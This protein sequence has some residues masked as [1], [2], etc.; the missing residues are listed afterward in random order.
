MVAAQAQS[1]TA[2]ATPSSVTFNYQIAGTIPSPVAV[3]V[4][5]GTLTAAYTT[6]ISPP[7]TLWVTATSGTGKLPDNL[8][9]R[10]NPTSL[11]QGQI[12]ATITLSATGMADLNIVVTLNIT[13][14]PPVLTISPLT[15]S[16]AYPTS[17]VTS[18]P[19]QA[20][21]TLTTTATPVTFTTSVSGAPW[22]TVSPPTTGVVLPGDDFTLT[23][24]V[25]PTG[26]A[27]QAKAY[28]GKVVVVANGVAA[29][30]KTQNISVSLTMNPT[31]PTITT[32]WPSTVQANIG[33]A[34]LT[35]I[36]TGFYA[37]TTVRAGTTPLA[38]P[39]PILVSSTQI[40]AVVPATMLTAAGTTMNIIVSN[41]APGG[42]CP[43]PAILTVSAAPVVQAVLNAASYVPGAVSPGEIVALFG[44]GIGPSAPVF[45][46][47]TINPG[48]ADTSIGA[49]TVTIGGQAAPILYGDPDQITVQV[50]YEVVP[51]PAAQ[52]VSVTNTTATPAAGSVTIGTQAPGIFTAD[53]SGVG[54]AA[55]IVTSATTGAVALNTASNP[56]HAGDYI[57]LYL[58]G[59]GDWLTAPAS[60]TGYL[61]P[62]TISPLP[63]MP[64][65]PTVTIGGIAASVSYAGVIPGCIIGLLQIN[66][67]VPVG[68]AAGNALVV[69]TIASMTTQGN[70][71]VTVK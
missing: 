8:S 4:R 2:T 47:S 23:I 63:Q 52:P 49:L 33:A 32:L 57:S 38:T 10:V 62:A 61:V 30:N 59:E 25:D 68:V 15:V 27:P 67:V 34:T 42:D 6:S 24:S 39:A 60:H 55:A 66:V 53:G 17:P 20:T 44:T 7:G 14:A 58:T 36:G 54:Q 22:L 71:T 1:V 13:A 40:Q 35:I 9:V 48:F 28:T 51:G 65:L 69:V 56:A 50:P 45:M 26:L 18:P 64:T 46:S 21:V 3:A 29:A 11:P 5:A 43:T 12:Q 16:L 31:A 41:P 37:G 70:V 19:L